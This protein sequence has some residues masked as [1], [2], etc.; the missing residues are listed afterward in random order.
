MLWKLSPPL[1]YIQC[2]LWLCFVRCLHFFLDC[3]NK[4]I[5]LFL[6]SLY[7]K[8]TVAL[9]SFLGGSRKEMANGKDT[10]SIGQHFGAF[11]LASL[12]NLGAKGTLRLQIFYSRPPAFTPF[13]SYMKNINK[14][15]SSLSKIHLYLKIG[16]FLKNSIILGQPM[17]AKIL[18]LVAFVTTIFSSAIT[19][20]DE[21]VGRRWKNYEI[22]QISNN[23][24]LNLISLRLHGI[25]S[26]NEIRVS[27]LNKMLLL[28]KTSVNYSN[29]YLMSRFTCL[30]KE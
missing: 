12:R 30:C 6:I 15:N 14:G 13:W 2:R 22:F 21:V 18:V 5:L 27:V 1:S 4:G 8:R 28:L 25:I 19:H 9:A 20:Y 24:G 23:N 16:H 10:D 7:Y 29:V 11:C 26:S 3:N 17:L